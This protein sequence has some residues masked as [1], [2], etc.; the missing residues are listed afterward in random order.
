MR[1]ERATLL[2]DVEEQG[3]D[4]VDAAMRRLGGTLVRRSLDE[5]EAEIAVAED[6]QREARRIA[7]KHLF[8]N[9]RDQH[10]EQIRAKLDDLQ[11]KLRR[12]GPPTADA[13]GGRAKM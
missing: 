3:P 1:V 13:T 8:E 6:A 4:P 2:A 11:A 10:R 9:R 7:R 12:P 5:V